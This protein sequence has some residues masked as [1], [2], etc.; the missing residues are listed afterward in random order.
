[1]SAALLDVLRADAMHDALTVLLVLAGAA[2]GVKGARAMGCAL[3]LGRSLDLIRA[4]RLVI[5]GAVALV[6]AAG[7]ATG[8]NGFF[9]LAAVFVAEELYETALVAAIIRSGETTS[10][11]A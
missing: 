1:M 7:V 4:I 9:V 3:R 5:F 8:R 2:L 6:C 11:S 10:H